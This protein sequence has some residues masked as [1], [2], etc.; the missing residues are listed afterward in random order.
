[1]Q[2]VFA[3]ILLLAFIGQTFQ[4]GF[5]YVD[6][7][8]DKAEYVKNCVNKARP[9]MQCNGKCQLMKK[10]QQQE[11]EQQKAPEMKLAGKIEVFPAKYDGVAILSPVFTF[12]HSYILMNEGYP[13]DQVSF[14]FH[15]PSASLV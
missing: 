3:T 5:Y 10:I 13:V 7:L 6:Y 4:Q 12:T 8:V 1:M 2:K 11:R 15:P 14:V 9:K